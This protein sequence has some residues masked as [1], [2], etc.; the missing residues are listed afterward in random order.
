MK[1]CSE[2]LSAHLNT[3]TVFRY[4]DCW[5][6]ETRDGTV[7]TWS[8]GD[9]PVTYGGVTYGLGPIISGGKMRVV[10]G[11]EVDTQDITISPNGTLFR[12]LP[13][14]SAMRR[15]FF[16]R[17]AVR[18]TRFFFAD[19]SDPA[20]LGG[21]LTF[22]GEATDIKP[23]TSSATITVQTDIY[24]LQA[25]MPRRTYSATCTH[26]F[27][28]TGCGVDRSLYSAKARLSGGSSARALLLQSNLPAPSGYYAQGTVTFEDG[29][30][31]GLSATIKADTLTSA[32]R[33]LSLTGP[34]SAPPAPGDQIYILPGCDRTLSLP[35]TYSIDI[36][37]PAALTYKVV[38]EIGKDIVQIIS[39]VVKQYSYRLTNQDGSY[40]Y[41]TY[42]DDYYPVWTTV[43]SFPLTRVEGA[44]NTKEYSIA[45]DFTLTFHADQVGR[46]VTLHYT[47]VASGQ[48]RTCAARYNNGANFAGF[49]YIPKAE[50]A[51]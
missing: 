41:E 24:L 29:V 26:V 6:I 5:R 36:S 22:S 46:V 12:G 35:V 32:G 10:R 3:A 28:D 31:A 40:I 14:L 16:D 15:G 43:P 45:S 50:L 11:L 21:I 33:K 9:I 4:V 1:S 25:Q 47:G 18:K 34:L 48:G 8:G 37:V 44:P 30:N 23:A 7:L 20:P 51:V 42:S 39:C 2:A 49:P 38:P 13:L 17:A 27:G 19:W